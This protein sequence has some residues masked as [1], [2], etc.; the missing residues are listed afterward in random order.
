MNHSACQCVIIL[1]FTFSIPCLGASINT[2][3]TVSGIANISYIVPQ[4]TT[5]QLPLQ[6]F[7]KSKLL[8]FFFFPLS[9]I[10]VSGNITVYSS[11]SL[12]TI[13]VQYGLNLV[14]KYS[15]AQ[16][17]MHVVAVDRDAVSPW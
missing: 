13:M 15:N 7:Y 2:K 10:A 4:C 16:R 12:A 11:R 6:L 9:L 8:V 14:N 1:Y 3:G 5:E 17:G